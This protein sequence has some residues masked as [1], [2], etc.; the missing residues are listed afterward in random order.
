[1]NRTTDEIDGLLP[2][3]SERQK[4]LLLELKKQRSQRAI[5]REL[6]ISH[7]A[8]QQ[9]LAALRSKAARSGWA[10]GHDMQHTVPAPFHVKG[11]SS[12][13][14]RRGKLRGQWVKSQIDEGAKLEHLIRA[15]KEACEDVPAV[16]PV[17]AAMPSTL[18]A[19][20]LSVYPMGDPH[21][22]MYAWA[23]ETGASYDLEIAERL[24]FGAVDHLAGLAPLGSTALVLDLGDFFHSDHQGNTTRKSGHQLDVDSRWAKVLRCG[25][26]VMYRQIDRLLLQH[27]HVHVRCEIGNHDDHTSVMLGLA[28][29][30][31]YRDEPRVTIHTTPAKFFY[32]EWGRCLLGSTHLDTVKPEQLPGIMAVDQHEAWGRTRWRQWYT[33][34]EHHQR[35]KDLLGCTV[36]TFRT[37]AAADSWHA[38]HGYRSDRDMRLDVWHRERGMTHRHIVGVEQLESAGAS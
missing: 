4:Q 24:L 15:I 3:A 28:L 16:A 29:E 18:P 6:G 8:V 30:Q 26:R 37:T 1:M 34:H 32:F 21:V 27:C 5:A 38:A 9:S 33:G 31:R 23:E 14:D 11:V 36:E 12:Y 35:V 25:I 2:Y 19:D 17:T 20:Q 22:G 7:Q 13:Y 10:P